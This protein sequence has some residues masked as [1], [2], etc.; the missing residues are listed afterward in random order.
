MFVGSFLGG[1]W[2]LL[3]CWVGVVMVCVC[4][5]VEWCDEIE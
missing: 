3:L 4:E 2:L 5:L 1:E